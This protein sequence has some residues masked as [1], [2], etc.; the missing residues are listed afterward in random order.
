MKLLLLFLLCICL[1]SCHSQEQQC[2]SDDEGIA[3]D[4]LR[5]H[6]GGHDAFKIHGWRWHT[7]AVLREVRLIEKNMLSISDVSLQ[8]LVDHTISFNL[9]GLQQ[10]ERNLFH[11]WLKE[12]INLLPDEAARLAFQH[13]IEYNI[14]Q[15]ELLT[16][17][18]NAMVGFG[19]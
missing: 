1:Q 19:L 16:Q 7:L 14:R 11:P 15:Q 12:K 9:K 18:G 17:G 2:S 6:S 10:V 5:N 8:Q 13:L 4:Y 3:G